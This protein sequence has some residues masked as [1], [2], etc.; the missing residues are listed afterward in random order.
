MLVLF[1]TV[2]KSQTNDNDCDYVYKAEVIPSPEQTSN[3]NKFATL[4]WDFS[5]IIVNL[6][7]IEIEIQPI[8]DC[9]KSLEAKRLKDIIVINVGK[10]NN[11]VSGSK[12]FKHIEMRN[13]CFKWRVVLKTDNC[14]KTSNWK[15]HSF[16]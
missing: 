4:N 2:V 6:K 15:F 11:N 13:K 7:T 3:S 8:F 12:V 10:Q 16:Y 9:Y 14:E 5:K 1:T